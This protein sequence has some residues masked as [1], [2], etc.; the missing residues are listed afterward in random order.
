MRV[1][2]ARLWNAIADG[3]VLFL[4]VY[5]TVAH[6]RSL[7]AD[8]LRATRLPWHTGF[9]M[10]RRSEGMSSQKHDISCLKACVRTLGPLG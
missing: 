8:G 7:S 2:V 5:C 10:S 3:L 1:C 9:N 6:N 4:T